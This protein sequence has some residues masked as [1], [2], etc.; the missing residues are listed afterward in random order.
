[1]RN[2]SVVSVKRCFHD[3]TSCAV[4]RALLAMTG[5]SNQGSIWRRIHRAT[6]DSLQAS[7]DDRDYKYEE[8]KKVSKG[9]GCRVYKSRFPVASFELLITSL[10]S[11]S[12]RTV[13]HVSDPN[14]H[15]HRWREP[16][17]V[18]NLKA[19]GEEVFKPSKYEV[20]MQ[21]PRRLTQLPRHC[22]CDLSVPLSR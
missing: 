20:L 18:R 8:L 7:E 19:F 21:S 14:R 13:H 15:S 1:M 9:M 5:P 17:S 12:Y 22:R 4:M 6:A 3:R 16:N 11:L 10:S 2:H